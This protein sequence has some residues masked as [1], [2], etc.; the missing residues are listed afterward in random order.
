MAAPTKATFGL[1]GRTLG[2]SWSPKIHAGLGSSPYEL[3]EL[4]PDE[5][6]PF[7]REGSWRGLNVTIPYKRVAAE[8]ADLRSPRVEAL[9]VAN[10]LVHDEQGRVFAENT[11]VLGFGYLLDRFFLECHG[12]KACELLAGRKALVLGTGGAAQ[13]VHASLAERGAQTVLISRTGDETYA[14][15]VERQADAK[16]GTAQLVAIETKENL[17]PRIIVVDPETNMTSIPGV[18]AGGDIVL[19]AATVILA[20]GEGRRAAAGI[21]SYLNK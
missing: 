20:M 15:L 11:D 4:E 18:F 8:A 5:V 2:H 10:T 14:T 9:G 17:H 19:G 1:L 7:I 3:I 16:S 6:V 12:Q 13:A 21:N